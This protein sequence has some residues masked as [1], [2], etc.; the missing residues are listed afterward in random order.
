MPL[1]VQQF[2]ST[3][4]HPKIILPKMYVWFLCLGAMTR[5][6]SLVFKVFCL[7]L[8]TMQRCPIDG[9]FHA[10]TP[11]HMRRPLQAEAADELNSRLNYEAVCDEYGELPVRVP[12]AAPAQATLREVENMCVRHLVRRRLYRAM[13]KFLAGEE[14]LFY[15]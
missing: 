6:L 8:C 2:L 3:L 14:P 10:D 1:N 5:A 15:M 11:L 13:H 4:S 9:R 12:P 7:V